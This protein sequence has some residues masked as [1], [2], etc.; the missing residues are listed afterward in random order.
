MI[1]RWPSE[2][3]LAEETIE[4]WY[5]PGSNYV[6]DFHGDPLKAELVVFSDGNHHMAL[7]PALRAY[8]REHSRI[9][10][11]FYATTPPYPIL[12]LLKTGAIRIGN[13]TLSV[14]P[15]VFI[16]PPHVLDGL[17]TAGNM[18]TH[19]P[20]AQIRGSVLLFA[21][22]NPKKI[23]SIADLMRTD[24]R[25]FIS[26]PETEKVS[27]DG[28]RQTL[29]AFANLQGLN[30]EDFSQA[31]FRDS[32]VFGQSIHHR[33]AP[34]AIACGR[35]DVAVVYY[36]LAL[37]YTT[38]FPDQFDFMALGGARSDPETPPQELV[39]KINIGL[40]DDGGPWGKGFVDFMLSDRVARIY[41]RHGLKHCR[42]MESAP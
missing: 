36:H 31:V 25:L 19:K 38:I 32:A 24:V 17:E 7:L 16:S 41:N 34:E 11:I 28:Y 29:E 9:K 13:L 33:E 12:K 8:H 2:T 39:A 30:S 26:N 37:R 6:L 22:D 15:N 18:D 5:Q 27:Y 10:D 20:L 21:K 40:I 4:P 42:P 23:Q 35:A 14:R 3:V 1:L